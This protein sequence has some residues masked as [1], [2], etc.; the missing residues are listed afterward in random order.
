VNSPLTVAGDYEVGLAAF[1]PPTFHVTGSLVAANDGSLPPNSPMNACEPLVNAAQIAGNIA[2]VDRGTCPFVVKAKNVQEA[3]AIAMVVVD[4]MPG[5][6]PLGMSGVDPTVTIPTVRLTTDD[7][8]VIKAH[9]AAGVNV[10]MMF[11]PTQDAG[12]REGKVLVYTPT[13]FTLGS[14]VSH[15]DISAE[16]SLLME[17]SIT[18]YVSSNPDLTLKQYQDIGWFGPIACSATTGRGPDVVADG[19]SL[20][21]PYPNPT[22]R[23]ATVRFQIARPEFVRLSVVD[24][25]GRRIRSLHEGMMAPG[26]HAMRWDGRMDSLVEAPAGVYLVSLRTSEGVWTQ[27][28]TIAP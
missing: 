19:A 23:G 9:V 17:P 16:P 4:T 11:D 27:R 12:T 1:G 15:W 2:L 21:A 20:A 10:T 13:V 6:P 24:V 22:A 26:D 3:G 25:N 8:T 7:G 18:P 5:C 28:I 14:S